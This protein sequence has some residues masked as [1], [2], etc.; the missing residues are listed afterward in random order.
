[1][2]K[3]IIENTCVINT[4]KFIESVSDFDIYGHSNNLKQFIKKV[5]NKYPFVEDKEF[6]EK[7]WEIIENS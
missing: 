6:I 1:M 5:Q 7:V 3:K 2:A 4:E